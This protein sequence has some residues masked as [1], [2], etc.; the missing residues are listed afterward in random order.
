MRRLTADAGAD[1]K[2]TGQAPN[3]PGPQRNGADTGLTAYT[4]VRSVKIRSLSPERT[5]VLAA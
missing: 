3:A 1:I 4:T 2:I 5:V